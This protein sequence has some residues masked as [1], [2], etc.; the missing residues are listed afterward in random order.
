MNQE[1]LIYKFSIYEQQI[2]Q[3]QEQMGAVERGIS[4]LKDLELGLDEIKN[5]HGNEIMAAIG[6]GIFVKAKII[7]ENLNVDIGN[8]NFV[9]KSVDETKIIL[10]KQWERL[11]EIKDELNRAMSNLEKEINNLMVEAQGIS[12]GSEN[13]D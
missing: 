9:K 4:D 1:E 12:A 13:K 7:D 3:L 6:R 10:K 2:N 5:S 8:G 11:G